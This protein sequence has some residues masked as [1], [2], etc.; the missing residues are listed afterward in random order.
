MSHLILKS[1]TSYL[2]LEQGLKGSG[3]SMNH[4]KAIILHDSRNNSHIS[5][6]VVHVDKNSSN[7]LYISSKLSLQLLPH[8]TTTITQYKMKYVTL[9]LLSLLHPRHNLFV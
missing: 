3:K 2:L 6:Y 8:P 4:M 9:D 1:R 5:E 7:Q